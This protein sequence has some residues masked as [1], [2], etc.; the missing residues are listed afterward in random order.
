MK[1]LL[2]QFTFYYACCAVVVLYA[3]TLQQ[4][5][6]SLDTYLP[7]YNAALSCQHRI[8]SHA[9][10]GTLFHRY[11][12]VLEELRL[13]VLGHCPVLRQNLQDE[14]VVGPSP[15]NELSTGL[16]QSD[17]EIRLLSA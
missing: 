3:H 13:E 14:V 4:R 12:L 16:V 1:R 17:E 2:S 6:Q 8:F 5:Q 9:Q 7:Y 11:G 10:D 15:S